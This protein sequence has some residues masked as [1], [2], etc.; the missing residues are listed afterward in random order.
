[1]I[2]AR[3]YRRLLVL[4]VEE[5]RMIEEHL[6]EL[7]QQMANLLTA[8]HDAVQRLAEVPGLGVVRPADHR[9]G[10]RDRRDL[11]LLEA[12]R[13]VDGRLPG[14]EESAGVNYNHRCPKGNRQM[15]RILNQAAN[16]AVKAKGTIFAEQPGMIGRSSTLAHAGG[17]SGVANY[18]VVCSGR[19]FG[20]DPRLTR[21]KVAASL[22]CQ[23]DRHSERARH[24]DRDRFD[25]CKWTAAKLGRAHDPE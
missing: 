4:T 25:G 14:N 24:S 9:R 20:R 16:A 22:E 2:T 21:A 7:D 15:R 19:T 23:P 17:V 18:A 6:G 12:S 3:H 10:P 11:P 1:M 13:L 8:H 5:L